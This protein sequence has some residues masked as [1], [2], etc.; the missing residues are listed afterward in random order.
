MEYVGECSKATCRPQPTL[1]FQMLSLFR[2][3]VK[4]EGVA[5]LYRGLDS[6][7]AR[8]VVSGGG[9]LAGYSWLKDRASALGLL[10]DQ[11]MGVGGAGDLSLR[12]VL[13]STAAA[14]AALAA[15]PF[16]CTRTRQGMPGAGGRGMGATMVEIVQKVRKR[17]E[18][19]RGGRERGPYLTPLRT[20]QDGARALFSGSGAVMGRAVSFN[21]VSIAQEKGKGVGLTE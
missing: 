18:R 9:R 1:P 20:P 12:A 19:E 11:G 5:T 8:A 16:D 17:R 6:A 15:A 2:D 4:D 3:I 14:A 10:R 21:V 7:L 13:A